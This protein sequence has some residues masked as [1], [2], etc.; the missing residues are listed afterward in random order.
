MNKILGLV[1]FRRRQ[2]PRGHPR[3]PLLLPAYFSGVT[4]A[5]PT[6]GS[7]VWYV[8]VGILAGIAGSILMAVLFRDKKPILS[9]LLNVAKA[10][11]LSVAWLAVLSYFVAVT[12]IPDLGTWSTLQTISAFFQFPSYVAVYVSSPAVVWVLSVAL[13]VGFYSA[14]VYRTGDSEAGEAIEN[15]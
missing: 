3:P 10:F 14:L 12:S 1:E 6:W 11:I 4:D 13:Y 15:G 7:I 9:M 2:R 5:S 8:Y